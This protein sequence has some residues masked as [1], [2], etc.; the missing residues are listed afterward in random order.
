[1]RRQ[2]RDTSLELNIEQIE[3]KG[4]SRSLTEIEFL[5]LILVIL[6]VIVPGTTVTAEPWWMT[7]AMLSYSVFILGFNYMNLNTPQT[8]WKLAV[9]TWVMISFIT[10]VLWH[11]GNVDSPLLNLYLLV[12][13]SSAIT[14]SKLMTILEIILIFIFYFYLAVRNGLAF[15]LVEFTELMVY[16]SP[17]VLVAYIA[18]MLAS[19][20]HYGKMMFKA[21]SETDEMT[22]LFSSGKIK[23]SKVK[24][25]LV[26]GSEVVA[27]IDT[28]AFHRVSSDIIP[29]GNARGIMRS[30]TPKDDLTE[31]MGGKPN[32]FAGYGLTARQSD[33]II[34]SKQ[35]LT[36]LGGLRPIRQGVWN[37]SNDPFPQKL[38]EDGFRD[39]FGKKETILNI[40]KIDPNTS[41]FKFL[42]F[43]K[44]KQKTGQTEGEIHNVL[45]DL[46]DP[47]KK[48]K[49]MNHLGTVQFTPFAGKN[50][51]TTGTQGAGLSDILRTV[52]QTK[53]DKKF[54]EN[55]GL[56]NFD[57]F[58]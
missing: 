9:E 30:R 48:T 12:I 40:K 15:N 16:F 18:T 42:P 25:D 6:Y 36:E 7:I 47:V 13:I 35:S 28:V 19:D 50:I 32:L 20:V 21:L 4:F 8:A 23:L 38:A 10:F 46:A 33:Q 49:I 44:V 55:R 37:N 26:G 52:K 43:G 17:F 58:F 1:M 3:L 2:E 57:D 31:A 53:A 5:L 14:L 39:L 51:R 29:V 11:T 27:D 24:N 22:D 54:F 56:P 45:N 34:S 41:P